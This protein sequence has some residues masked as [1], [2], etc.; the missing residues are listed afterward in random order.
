MEPDSFPFPTLPVELGR[1]EPERLADTIVRV[2]RAL[3][4]LSLRASYVSELFARTPIGT[5]AKALDRVCARA[6]QAE[7]PAREA[8]LS[9]VDALGAP[10]GQSVAQSLREEAAGESL[11]ALERLIRQPPPARETIEADP[12]KERIPDYVKGRALTLGERKSLARRPDRSLIDKLLQD[13][14]PDVIRRLLKNPR[15]TEDDVVRLAGRRPGRPGVLAEIARTPQWSHRTRV[16]LAL[17]LNPDTPLELAG[18]ISGLLVRQELK[19][20]A[21]STHVSPQLRA[22]CLEHLQRRPPGEKEE[23]PGREPLQ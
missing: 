19:M 17:M 3:P 4:D 18:P 22:L 1:V 13:P 15:L 23:E 8:L 5:L 10:E 6:E 9:V 7:E 21:E 14:H 16:R 20:V 11:L 12:T 2:T